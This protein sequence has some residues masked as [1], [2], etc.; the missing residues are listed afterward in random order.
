MKPHKNS[1]LK[2][3]TAKKTHKAYTAMRQHDNLHCHKNTT[4][5]CFENTCTFTLPREHLKLTLPRKKYKTETAMGTHK[6]S[7]CHKNT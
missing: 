4:S 3:H 5:K 2:I 7:H 6:N 1:K